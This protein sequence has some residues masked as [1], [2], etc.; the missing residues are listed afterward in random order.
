[1]LDKLS[2]LESIYLHKSLIIINNYFLD[3]SIVNEIGYR[4]FKAVATN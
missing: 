3:E 2:K 1:M 4:G